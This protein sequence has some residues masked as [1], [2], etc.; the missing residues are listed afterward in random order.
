MKMTSLVLS[1]LI[2]MPVFAGAALA[3]EPLDPNKPM[4]VQRESLTYF[5]LNDA[6]R[7][8]DAYGALA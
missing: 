1:A 5:A 6:I 8:A 4:V 3:E 2:A 7:M